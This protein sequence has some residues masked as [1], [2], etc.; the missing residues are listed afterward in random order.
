MKVNLLFVEDSELVVWKLKKMLSGINNLKIIGTAAG[1]SEAIRTI[2]ERNPDLMILDLSLSEGSGFQVLEKIQNT[3]NKPYVIVL[4][5]NS[6]EF[7]RD[8][9]MNLGA[10]IF[11][12]KS[13]EFEKVYEILKHKAES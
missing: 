11:L 6:D 10:D 9:C 13:N 12:D 5:N 4:T 8:K 7:V 2:G 3:D 1:E